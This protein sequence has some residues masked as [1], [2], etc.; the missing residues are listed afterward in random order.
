MVKRLTKVGNSSAVILDKAIMDLVGLEEDGEILITVKDG[1][2]LVTPASPR[3]AEA[4][5]F[6]DAMHKFID[7]NDE[8]LRKLA[9]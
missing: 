4:E 9:K 3:V 8:V 5:A 2:I 6:R 7:A 1:T